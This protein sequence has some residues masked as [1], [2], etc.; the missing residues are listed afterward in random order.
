MP[1]LSVLT[2]L[3]VLF[4]AAAVAAVMAFGT[5]AEPPAFA[6]VPQAST[7]TIR[8]VP[9][10]LRDD[11][12]LQALKAAQIKAIAGVSAFHDFQFSDRVKESGITFKH[13]IV[14]DAG[15]TYKAAHYDH[16]NGLAIADI[17]GDGLTDVYFLSQVG[18]NQLVRN[19][20]G[21]MR[22]GASTSL[23][24]QPSIVTV[25]PIA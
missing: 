8:Y 2:G 5:R 18:G 9:D 4:S 21:G 13:R 16:G 24:T 22:P 25:P 1:R 12:W 20:G 10:D 7:A 6:A 3:S 11:S 23:T 15:K 17:D 14:D 19:L